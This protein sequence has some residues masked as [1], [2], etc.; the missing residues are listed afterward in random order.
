MKRFTL[1]LAVLAALSLS[2][3][4]NG[5]KWTPECSDRTAGKCTHEKTTTVKKAGK[6]H[7]A[8]AAFNKA[9]RK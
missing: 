5:G 3:C 9:M 7:K 6:K 1:A 8:D 4:A 2:A